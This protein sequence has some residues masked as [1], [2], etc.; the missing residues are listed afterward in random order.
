MGFSPVVITGVYEGSL[1]LTGSGIGD[2][3]VCV[4]GGGAGGC[5]EIVGRG[6]T[7]VKKM[8]ASN[9]RPRQVPPC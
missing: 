7:T 2:G 8:A 4:G 3:C 6:Y 9:I 5:Q 1:G